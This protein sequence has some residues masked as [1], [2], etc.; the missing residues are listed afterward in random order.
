MVRLYLESIADDTAVTQAGGFCLS[1]LSEE[2]FEMAEKLRSK[3]FQPSGPRFTNT[4]PRAVKAFSYTTVIWP[5][6]SKTGC[7][8][9]TIK[10]LH[11]SPPGK[12]VERQRVPI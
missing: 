3:V 11:P 10:A 1:A 4:I 12:F 2:G 7:I 6:A 9:E 8:F 5:W